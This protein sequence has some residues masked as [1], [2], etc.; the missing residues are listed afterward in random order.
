VRWLKVGL[1]ANE[2]LLVV[3]TCSDLVVGGGIEGDVVGIVV[4]AWN[5]QRG[6]QK[7]VVRGESECLGIHLEK[8]NVVNLLSSYNIDPHHFSRHSTAP[9]PTTLHT[10]LSVSIPRTISIPGTIPISRTSMAFWCTICAYN[11]I[12]EVRSAS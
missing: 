1:V 3:P 11:M 8:V 7:N 6:D 12:S 10:L 2:P 9:F 4:V 5:L